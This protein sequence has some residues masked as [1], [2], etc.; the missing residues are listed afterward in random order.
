MLTLVVMDRTVFSVAGLAAN[1]VQLAAVKT[2][3]PA[4][5]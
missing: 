4:T 1:L 3:Y 2:R 5:A